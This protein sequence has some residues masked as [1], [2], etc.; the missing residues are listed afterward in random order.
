MVKSSKYVNIVKGE[1][2]SGRN[3]LTPSPK[4]LD[5]PIKS[6]KTHQ[7]C[8]SP[9]LIELM[10]PG[11][12]LFKCQGS[13][14]CQ[15]SVWR[16][17]VHQNTPAKLFFALVSLQVSRPKTLQQRF[18]CAGVSAGVQSWEHSSHPCSLGF[19]LGAAICV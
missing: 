16:R 8:R 5:S 2:I 3:E 19:F 11:M 12:A 18:F 7:W 4:D 1:V 17:L 9:A 15:E 13:R 14:A 6:W 10:Q